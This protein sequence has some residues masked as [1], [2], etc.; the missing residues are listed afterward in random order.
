M[1]AIDEGELYADFLQYYHTNFNDLP[2]DEMA[3]LAHH[4]PA[5]SRIKLKQSGLTV[6]IEAFLLGA[7]LDCFKLQIW[8]MSKQGTAKPQS[9]LP[10]MIINKE[11][12]PEKDIQVYDTGE[13]FKSAWRK[14]TNGN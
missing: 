3:T 1:M 5:N 11:N 12:K 2:V 9:I 6:P 8:S 4:L 13:D 7:L 14:M 10:S